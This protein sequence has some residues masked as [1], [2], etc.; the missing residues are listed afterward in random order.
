M[1]CREDG[2]K[3]DTVY[4]KSRLYQEPCRY[5]TFKLVQKVLRYTDLYSENVN[6]I[7]TRLCY[8]MYYH[9]DNKY[10]CLVV[11]GLRYTVNFW[12]SVF[13]GPKNRASQGFTMKRTI[14]CFSI[15]FIALSKRPVHQFRWHVC[16][17]RAFF[18]DLKAF[19]DKLRI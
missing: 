19:S 5:T 1:Q 13:S 14:E 8:V 7:T 4:V 11:I 10:H 9:G 3:M 2:K 6:P 16:N 18:A 15:E 12:A 17:H